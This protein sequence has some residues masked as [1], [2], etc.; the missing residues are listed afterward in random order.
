MIVNGIE[1]DWMEVISGVPQGSV[2]S[3]LLFVIYIR[4]LRSLQQT[5]WP[6]Q[7]GLV[8]HGKP[9]STPD[10]PATFPP[11][12]RQSNMKSGSQNQ[13]NAPYAPLMNDLP[14]SIL[15]SEM[16]LYADDA[17]IFRRITDKNDNRKL[18]ENLN[19]MNEW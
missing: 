9:K 3:H 14:K 18:Q 11:L 13:S 2:L 15:N 17:K 4:T 5:G 19:R 1:S 6:V 12:A 8:K 16:L 10:H 7:G